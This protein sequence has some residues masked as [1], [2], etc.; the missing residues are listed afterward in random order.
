M[1]R[2]PL[3]FY[4]P[5]DY[6]GGDLEDDVRRITEAQAEWDA[7]FAALPLWKRVVHYVFG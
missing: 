5:D 7:E 1:R 2:R 6:T 4:G 3:D